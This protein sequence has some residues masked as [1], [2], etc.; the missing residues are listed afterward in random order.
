VL[1]VA[2]FTV[3]M[4]LLYTSNAQF[5]ALVQQCVHPARVG[6]V[7]GFV[8]FCA[9][10]AAIIAPAVT[11]FLVEDLESWTAAFS[12]AAG[13]AVLGAVVLAVVRRPAPAQ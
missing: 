12:L 5:W 1:S 10:L 3:T 6:A 11:G 13:L 9:N 4:L 2:L 7:S 8:H